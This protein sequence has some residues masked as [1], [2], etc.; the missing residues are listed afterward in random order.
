[1]LPNP[2]PAHPDVSGQAP[3]DWVAL[4]HPTEVGY[5]YK[6]SGSHSANVGFET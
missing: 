4:E 1:M 6:M 5:Y 2:P 3:L